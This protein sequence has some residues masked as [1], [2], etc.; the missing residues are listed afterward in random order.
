[1][2][3]KL[4]SVSLSLVVFAVTA[5]VVQ[6]QQQRAYRG[7]YQSVRGTILRIENR[8]N[9]F[10]DS[11]QAAM[12]RRDAAAIVSSEDP[13]VFVSDF[14]E[15]VRRLHDRFDRRASNAA[16][17][18]DVLNRAARID[19]FMRRYPLDSRSQS[20]WSS[21][22]ADLNLLANAY[23]VSW[24]ETT[25]YTPPYGN[26]PY[27]NRFGIRLTGTYRLD[28]SNSDDAQSMA[29]RATRI[30]PYEERQRVSD[31]IVR[32]LQAPDEIAI[33]LRGRTVTLASTRAPQ[34]TFEADGRDRIETRPNGRTVRARATLTGQQLIVSTTGDTGNDFTVTF[35]PLDNGQRLNVTRQIFVQ[36]L[37]RPVVARSS[38]ER[39]DNIARFDIY[40]PQN[41]PGDYR[42][43]VGDFVVPNG[44]IVVGT[45]ND[46]L[47]TQTASVGDRFT[48]RVNQPVEFDGATIEGHVAEVQRSGRLTGR[49][50][51]TLDFDNIRLRDGRSYRFAGIVDG[52]NTSNGETVRVDAEGTVR[53]DSQTRRTEERAAIGTAIGALIG[54]IAGGG[55]GAAIGAVAGAGT[56]AGSVYVQ[57]RDDLNLGRGSE[58]RIRAGAPANLQR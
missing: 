10:R 51:M 30:F 45:L 42:A 40:T 35:D 23:S 16:D 57:G 36:G 49:S 7:T 28:A 22:R 32:R 26:P 43:T 24:P 39:I 46:T 15:S 54:A 5:A 17:A 21:M 18:Q 53:D 41:Y 27:G 48:L 13:F 3:R 8:T 56:G 31:S 34:I 4:L 55:K 37:T 25:R 2:K 33:D 9:V 14:S 58:I 19:D 52:V 47:S 12:N 6:A 29:D 38:Y 1:M 44:T 11:L 50:V 20:D